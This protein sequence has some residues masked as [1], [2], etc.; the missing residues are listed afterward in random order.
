MADPKDEVIPDEV[1]DDLQ[2]PD[3]TAEDVSGGI[4]RRRLENG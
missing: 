1:I 4:V 2:V 3:E